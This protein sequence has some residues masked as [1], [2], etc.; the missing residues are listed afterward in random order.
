MVDNPQAFTFLFMDPLKQKEQYFIV[1]LS[2]HYFQEVVVDLI[3]Q[4]VDFNQLV[5]D[6]YFV[7]QV[8]VD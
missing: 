1:K 6:Y 5:E 7:E 8:V 4:V 2:S 3:E